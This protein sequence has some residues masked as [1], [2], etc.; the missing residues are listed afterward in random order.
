M[1]I[2]SFVLLLFQL[3]KKRKVLIVCLV[4]II[5]L[6]SHWTYVRNKAWRDELSLSADIYK[7]SPN[8]ARVNIIYGVSLFDAGR[9]DEALPIME[10]ALQLYAK[11]TIHQQELFD[12]GMSI[13]S[14]NL[15]I[16]Y[17]E[18]GEYQKAIFY[19]NRSLG[20]FY[21]SVS[22]HYAIGLCYTQI[23]RFE[24][25]INHLTKAMEFTKHHLRQDLG[26]SNVA[27]IEQSLNFAKME[28]KRQKDRE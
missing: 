4:G 16:I 10:R 27:Q 23:G 17:T 11:E 15:G 20:H 12:Y 28:L 21:F 13:T 24:E 5:L 3:V 7:K 22:A 1:V 9:T 14:L 2:F 6:F 18:R 26:D 25:A 8:K 19:L